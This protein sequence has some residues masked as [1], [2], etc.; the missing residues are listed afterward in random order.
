MVNSTKKSKVFFFLFLIAFL[1]E[2]NAI[3]VLGRELK[4]SAQL[5]GGRE[6]GIT[7]GK[8]KKEKV[9]SWWVTFSCAIFVS[10]VSLFVFV[11]FLFLRPTT[12][13]VGCN[14]D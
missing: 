7:K 6:E 14:R 1:C 11:L 5:Q 4:T 13:G 8:P 9:G 10:T 12:S 2:I 3:E